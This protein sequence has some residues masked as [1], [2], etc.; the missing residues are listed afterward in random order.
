MGNDRIVRVAIPIEVL[1][2]SRIIYVPSRITV[3]TVCCIDTPCV[4]RSLQITYAADALI[5]GPAELRYGATTRG[6]GVV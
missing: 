5:V 2:M 3:D 4:S 6:L 1:M